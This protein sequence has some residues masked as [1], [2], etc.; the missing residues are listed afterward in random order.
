MMSKD[1]ANN[2]KLAPAWGGATISTNTDTT[3][4]VVVDSLGYNSIVIGV[5]TG[6]ITDGTYVLKILETDNA[7]G[8]TGAA[9]VAAYHVQDSVVAAS[10]NTVKKVGAALT[11]RYCTL[12]LT[13]TGTTSGGVFAGAIAALGNALNRPVA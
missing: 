11:K 1:L 6:T 4:T 13:S 7:D 12:R 9:E 8:T 2:I 3:S 10:D 5:L